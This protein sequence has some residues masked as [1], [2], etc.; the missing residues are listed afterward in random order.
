MNTMT[1]DIAYKMAET[2]TDFEQGKILF[3][4]YVLS[5]G[6]DLSFQDF[7]KELETIDRQYHAPDG[8]LLLAFK[9]QQPAGCAGVRKSDEGIAEL[10]RMYVRADYRG[11]NIGGGLLKLSLQLATELGYK[12]IRLDTLRDMTR[13]RALYQSFGFYE[14]PPYRFNPLE[15]AIFMEKDL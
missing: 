15:G 6:V 1:G 8:G 2:T 12:K 9:D 3:R 7:E 10:K 5:L 11:Y 14:I 13:A 4:E